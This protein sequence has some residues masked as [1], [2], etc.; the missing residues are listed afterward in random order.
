MEKHRS[1]F[2]N[3][4]HP[5]FAIGDRVQFRDSSVTGGGVIHSELQPPSA[6]Y[7][8]VCWDDFAHPITHRRYSLEPESS[9]EVQPLK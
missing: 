7:I 9:F 8:R 1:G 6:D 5:T 2:M 4:I 3:D